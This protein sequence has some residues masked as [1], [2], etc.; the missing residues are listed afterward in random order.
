[1]LVIIMKITKDI[2]RTYNI[3]YVDCSFFLDGLTGCRINGVSS[4][5]Q[6]IKN[7]PFLTYSVAGFEW[8]PRIDLE[9]GKITCWPKGIRA[10]INF[11]LSSYH[12]TYATEDFEYAFEDDRLP[13]YL[14]L[15]LIDN[16]DSLSFT[17]NPN[18]YIE[19]WPDQNTIIKFIM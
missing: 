19:N 3:K 6:T 7:L 17:V 10:V 13:E 18:G 14:Q 12:C 2:K 5:A 15:D 4:S 16:S 8:N 11:K 1:M 9:T